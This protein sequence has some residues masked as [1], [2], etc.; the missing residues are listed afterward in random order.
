MIIILV[1]LAIAELIE[2][3]PNSITSFGCKK[4]LFKRMCLKY[5]LCQQYLSQNSLALCVCVCGTIEVQ[6]GGTR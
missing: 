1:P 5:L 2:Y 3:S 4:N 6:E